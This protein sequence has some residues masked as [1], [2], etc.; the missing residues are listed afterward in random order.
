MNNNSSINHFP[1]SYQEF[2]HLSRYA[3]WVEDENRRET[4]H[5]TVDRYIDYMCGVKCKGKIPKEIKEELRAAILGLQVMPSMRC[6]MTAGKALERDEI[7]GYNCSYVAVN[8]IRAFDETMYILMCGTGVGFSVERQEVNKLPEIS[9]DFHA[10]DT[11]IYVADSKIGWAKAFREL[12]SLLYVGQVPKWDM[13]NIR[14]AGSRLKTFGG[15]ASGPE[16]L[17]DLFRFAVAMFKGAAGRKLT[18]LECHDLMCKTAQVVVVGGVRRSACISLSNLSDDRMRHA[19]DGNWYDLEPQ[20]ALANNSVAYTER[21]EMGTFMAEWQALYNSKSGERGIFNREAAIKQ[22]AKNGRRDIEHD[23][24]TN[25]CSEII[26]RSKGLC[27]LTEVIIRHDD[28]PATIKNKVRLATILGTIQAT[29]T[30]FRYISKAW[31]TNAEE[32]CLLGVSMTGIMDNDL[33]NGQ[34]GRDKL[35]KNLEAFRQ[36]AIETNEEWAK[37]LKINQ[38]AAITCVKPSGTVSQLCDSA[39]G[40]HA[41]YSHYYIRTVRAD[42]KD[43]LAQLMRDQG[44]PHED[45]V[46]NPENLVFS[47]PVKAP[48]KAIVQSEVSAL[49]QLEMWQIYQDHWCEHKPSV[50]ISVKEKEWLQVAAWVYE[51]FNAVSGISF[52]PY[53]GHSYRQAPYQEI[54]EKE[55]KELLK[56]MPESMDWTKLAEYEKEDQSAGSKTMACSGENGACELVDLVK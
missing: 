27:N 45:D 35:V 39:S 22:A 13:S 55:Y 56:K 10:T 6:L 37:K 8:N 33:T 31:K 2:I 34:Y 47:F 12:L 7:A 24:G 29:L 48:E 46:I 38:A 28:T 4:W 54:D 25:P 52:L 1:T 23:F 3:R 53:A 49:S 15:R 43:P 32:E 50:T 40:I 19:K 14:P 42:K 11:T 5:E 36:V 30:D 20:R 26:L 16:P 41:R 9:D 44:V 17:E 18:S 21:P 51:H